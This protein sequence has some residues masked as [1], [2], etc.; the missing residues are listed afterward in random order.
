M[1]IVGPRPL[2]IEYLPWYNENEK[3]R[4]SVRPGLTGWAQI[5]GRNS[6]DW[7]ARF[8]LDVE[9]VDNL[10]FFMD[11]KIIFLTVKKVLT[12]SDVAEDTRAAE[13]NF[14]QIRSAKVKETV[15]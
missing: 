9:Y 1:S 4:H 15:E 2:L 6:A 12:A 7:D 13:G 10:S 11:V 3:R 14:A 8:S 5:N